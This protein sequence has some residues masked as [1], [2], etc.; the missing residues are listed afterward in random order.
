MD[1]INR[2]SAATPKISISLFAM[3][4]NMSAKQFFDF[5]FFCNR[6]FLLGVNCALAGGYLFLPEPYQ[7]C[8][9]IELTTIEL[10]Y[11]SFTKT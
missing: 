11:R 5:K 2:N 4:V 3:C 1:S 8:R 9:T 7:K 10:T 6:G